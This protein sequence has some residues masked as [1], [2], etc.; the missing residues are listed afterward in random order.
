MGHRYLHFICLRLCGG[1]YM[2][3]MTDI[4][5]N[6]SFNLMSSVTVGPFII[7]VSQFSIPHANCLCSIHT[8]LYSI[9]FFFISK[10][11]I[12]I[13]NHFILTE[14]DKILTQS[15]INQTATS[16]SQLNLTKRQQKVF[17]NIIVTIIYN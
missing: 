8:N 13:L 4:F 16:E 6:V 11:E 9:M 2:L 5:L 14:N 17:Q 15:D 3:C 10:Q 1:V 12:S 7:S